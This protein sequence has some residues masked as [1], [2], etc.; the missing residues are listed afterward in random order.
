[1]PWRT[2]RVSCEGLL[3]ILDAKLGWDFYIP[4]IFLDIFGTENKFGIRLNV[5]HLP[6]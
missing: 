2:C 5:T 3:Y 1:V 6:V 4:A